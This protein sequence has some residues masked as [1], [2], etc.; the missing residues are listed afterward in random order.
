[1]LEGA[2]QIVWNDGGNRT[3]IKEGESL[4]QLSIPKEPLTEIKTSNESMLQGRTW[5]PIFPTRS[6]FSSMG[7]SSIRPSASTRK[8][9]QVQEERMEAG[10]ERIVL[11]CILP[12]NNPITKCKT[13]RLKPTQ[14]LAAVGMRTC[15]FASQ[16]TN[17]LIR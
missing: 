17:P 2:V 14:L 16:A 9:E 4:P 13:T 6:S 11:Y 15:V 12:A 1:V 7:G 3:P 5:S 8:I 10:W